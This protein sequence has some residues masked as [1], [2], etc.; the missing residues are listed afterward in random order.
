MRRVLIS[1]WKAEIDKGQT[2]FEQFIQDTCLV[3]SKLSTWDSIKKVKLKTFSNWMQKTKAC[4]V[5]KI[6]KLREEHELHGRF[7]IIQGSRPELDE[8][9]G[10]YKMS[11]LPHSLCSVDG[12]SQ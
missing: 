9:I 5:D 12:R 7:L 1:K 4:V 2:E 10:Q 6:R 11:V 8:T 3:I